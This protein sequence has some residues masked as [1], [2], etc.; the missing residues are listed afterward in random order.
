MTKKHDK[1]DAKLSVYLTNMRIMSDISQIVQLDLIS[2][3]KKNSMSKTFI[4]P[5]HLMP[6]L[7]LWRS[8][9][10]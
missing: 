9:L 1:Y 4:S 8:V 5:R 2:P 10:L 3:N 6:S 7:S